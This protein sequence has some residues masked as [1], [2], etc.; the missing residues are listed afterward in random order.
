ME[1]DNYVFNHLPIQGVTSIVTDYVYTLFELFKERY[2][3][4]YNKNFKGSEEQH[5]NDCFFR[6]L[7]KINKSE[8]GSFT[9]NITAN[10]ITQTLKQ[11]KEQKD[12]HRSI[13]KSFIAFEKKD[14]DK[15][16]K[17]S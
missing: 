9:I 6:V 13:E 16:E 10:G 1:M 15:E 8:Y 2:T 12:K 11:F 7:D 4:Y 3:E 17:R 5:I 14:K